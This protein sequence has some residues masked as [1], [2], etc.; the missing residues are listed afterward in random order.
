MGYSSSLIQ[1]KFKDIVG[2]RYDSVLKDYSEFLLTDEEMVVPE[3]RSI[4]VPLDSFVHDIGDE[5]IDVFSAYDATISLAYITDAGVINLLKQTLGHESA[6][7]FRAKKE[8]YGQKLLE[9]TAAKLEERGFSTQTRMFVGHIGDDVARMAK[10]H[11]MVALCRRYADGEST[12]DSVS[13]IVLRLCQRV[14]TPAL[15][16]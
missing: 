15:I 8:E 3:I 2:K 13:P 10:N 11:D 5:A 16:Y 6:E 1:R 14:Q 4:L 12:D 7:E 9:R